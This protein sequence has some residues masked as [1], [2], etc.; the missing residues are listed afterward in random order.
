MRPADEKQR[1]GWLTAMSRRRARRER[2][3]QA[4]AEADLASHEDR[5]PETLSGGQRARVALM[6][7]LLSNPEAVLLDEPFSKLDADTRGAIRH[8]V[9]SHVTSRGLPTLMVTHDVQD[10][11][12]AAGPV[13]HLG[14]GEGDHA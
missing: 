9:F 10:A 8:I 1:A 7:T 4:L 6:R 2:A 5:D 12:S 11:L 3:I 14:N 13:V